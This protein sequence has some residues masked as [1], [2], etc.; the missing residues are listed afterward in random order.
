MGNSF[1]SS[2]ANLEIFEYGMMQSKDFEYKS[3]DNTS[4]KFEVCGNRVCS[5]NHAEEEKKEDEEMKE[6]PD[7][8]SRKMS[9][10]SLDSDKSAGEI[11]GLEIK[12][13]SDNYVSVVPIRVVSSVKREQPCYSFILLPKQDRGKF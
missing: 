5:H 10:E 12:G 7:D 6:Q 13:F 1:Y 4:F 9:I 11:K 2:L 3:I 8:S